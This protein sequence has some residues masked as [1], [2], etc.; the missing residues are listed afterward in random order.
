M[1][2]RKRG[3]IAVGLILLVLGGYSLYNYNP[4]HAFQSTF[5]VLPGKFLKILANLRDATR[6]TGTFQETSG[7]PVTFLIMSSAQFA[8]FQVNANNTANLYA[9]LDTAI[10]HPDFTSSIPDTYYM[11]FRHGSGLLSTTQTVTF[12]RTYTSVDIPAILAGLALLVLGAIEIYWGFRPAGRRAEAT[13][14]ANAV[15]SDAPPP[16]WP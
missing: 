1:A 15:A 12:Q 5:N 4:V 6:I 9:L 16:P 7:R 14:A 2:S 10:G 3:L 13:E 11:V 8:A